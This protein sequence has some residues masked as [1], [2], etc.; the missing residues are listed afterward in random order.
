MQ[1]YHDGL[2]AQKEVKQKWQSAKS[3]CLEYAHLM[4]DYFNHINQANSEEEEKQIS[5]K[6]KQQR[7]KSDL[8]LD[9]LKELRMQ[10]FCE[11]NQ[12]QLKSIKEVH[13]LCL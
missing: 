9:G 13:A 2:H 7:N 5:K 1:A 6:K 3:D 11:E 12:L 4:V 10:A 8:G